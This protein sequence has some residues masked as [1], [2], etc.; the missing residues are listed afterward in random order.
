MKKTD[1]KT[2]REFERKKTEDFGNELP[3]R[4]DLLISASFAKERKKVKLF[5]LLQKV[6]NLLTQKNDKDEI[7]SFSRI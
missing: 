1:T 5:L 3:F 6:R 4:S 2:E 7:I